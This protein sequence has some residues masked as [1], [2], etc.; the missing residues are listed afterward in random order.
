VLPLPG[1]A[2]SSRRLLYMTPCCLNLVYC[3]D[4]V[5]ELSAAD[6]CRNRVLTCGVLGERGRKQTVLLEKSDFES[7]ELMNP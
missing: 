1:D 5:Q 4:L 3:L 7:H 6:W 2:Q